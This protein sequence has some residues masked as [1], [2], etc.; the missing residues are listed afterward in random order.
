[1][2][3]L[4]IDDIQGIILHGYG[5][6][7]SACFVVLRL[8]AP[9]DTKTWLQALDVRNALSRPEDTERCI[10]IAFTRAGL[11]KLGVPATTMQLF[12]REFYEGMSATAHRQRLLGDVGDSSPER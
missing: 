12:S 5:K 3:L 7:A 2:S 9:N 1:M 8:T 6:L 10:N 11:N 4:Q